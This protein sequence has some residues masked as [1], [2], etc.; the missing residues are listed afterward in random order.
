MKELNEISFKDKDA[1]FGRLEQIASQ[2]NLSKE[3]RAQYE[4]E[5]KVYNDYFNTLE[6]GEKKARAEGL[7]KGMAEGMAIGMEKGM[8]KG[9]E[10]GM[11]KG[12]EQKNLD[13]AR[14]MKEKGISLDM[15][16]DITG[17]SVE[18][19]RLL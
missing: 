18:A 19:I 12:A 6:S 7:E 11:E 5:W 17:L 9:I 3:E 8:E 1:I 14:K 16:A 10:K 15:I 13:N 4:Y 2:A